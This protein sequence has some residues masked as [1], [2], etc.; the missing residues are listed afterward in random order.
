MFGPGPAGGV[1][2]FGERLDGA[3]VAANTLPE[4][5]LAARDFE[6]LLEE[7]VNRHAARPVVTHFDRKYVKSRETHGPTDKA[8]LKPLVIEIH[9]PADGEVSTLFDTEPR[10][11]SSTHSSGDKH[12]VIFSLQMSGGASFSSEDFAV[13]VS[14]YAGALDASVRNANALI[15][16]HRAKVMDAVRPVLEA[17]WRRTRLLRGALQDMNIPL[18]PDE[19]APA[20]IPVR[21]GA[22]S[23]ARIDAAA[24]E[25]G[26]EWSLADELAEGVISTIS[27]FSL[28]LERLP[29]TA[30]R[31]L[32][33]HE[34]TLR[35]VLLFVLNA[36]YRGM[37]TGETFIGLGKSDIL[38]RW[39]N[40]DA[41]VGE[42][43]IW[44]GAAALS[45][46][47]DQLLT[48]YTLWRQSHVALILFIRDPASATATIES[49]HH[50][51]AQHSR[52]QLALEAPEPSRRRD[53]TVV[54]S[55]DERRPATL[56][57]LP[58]VIPRS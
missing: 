54:T 29:Q 53:Y 45:E 4:D 15:A 57:L 50:T 20:F 23:M 42:C 38:L 47:I 46:G 21:P 16:E 10:V 55:G 36:N 25:G 26:R 3:V 11:V 28:A 56:T 34:E 17:R 14:K 49:A 40:R 5:T 39:E 24:A 19:S 33:E 43:K 37:A 18:E 58:V 22:L 2:G 52:T 35:D 9:V 27:D 30:N 1:R 6:L 31:L 7:I 13:V 12:E 41:F 8:V 51:I 32:G 48:R 44:R